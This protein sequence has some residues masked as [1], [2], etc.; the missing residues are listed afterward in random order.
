MTTKRPPAADPEDRERE[1]WITTHPAWD[2]WQTPNQESVAA[3]R[4]RDLRERKRGI[5]TAAVDA[6]A[7]ATMWHDT[8]RAETG[9]LY[10]FIH[11]YL[12]KM[13]NPTAMRWARKQQEKK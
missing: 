5:A 7:R 2:D 8:G 3:L 1:K 13:T 4:R 12:S 11:S 10:E 9:E 6:G